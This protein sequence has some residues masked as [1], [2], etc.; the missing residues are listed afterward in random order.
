MASDLSGVLEPGDPVRV[1]TG[2]VFTEGPLWHPDGFLYVSDINAATHYRVS[3]PNGEKT[4]IRRDSGGAN[5]ATFDLQG[6]LVMC[7]QYGRRLVRT[8]P[9]G[10]V[11]TLTDSYEGKK[12]N[13]TND[14][15]CR[16]DGSLYFTDPQLL[17]P[18]PERE[19][20]HSAIF[21]YMPDGELR[22]M[23]S[24]M[25]HPN[26]LAF[27][28]DETKLYA[29]N[30]RPN[31]HLYVFDILPDGALADGRLFAEMP[32][33]PAEPGATFATS[34]GLIR[35]MAEKGGVPDG[36][37]VDVEGR[38]FCTGPGGTWVWE[39]GGTHL[40][41]IRTPELPANVAF[42]DADSRSLYMTCRTSVYM[43]RTRA[44]GI[45]ATPP[46]A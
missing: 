35:P 3:L 5:G 14:V 8:E 25:N 9:D 41:I 43:L 40:G 22:L 7:E 10:R 27:S 4:V 32:Y 28:P 2:F 20:G 23:T 33:G 13:G 15:V 45:A 21:R 38:I 6:R 26:G 18:E 17:I 36:L 39:A 37:K 19:L 34:A 24:E 44:P 16:S 12:L 46:G 29:S 31:P 1:A 30:T 42:G 11:V